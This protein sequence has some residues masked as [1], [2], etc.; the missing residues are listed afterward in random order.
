MKLTLNMNIMNEQKE[1]FKK[2]KVQTR[3]DNILNLFIYLVS[4]LSVLLRK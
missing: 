3:E 2:T 4:P 1:R